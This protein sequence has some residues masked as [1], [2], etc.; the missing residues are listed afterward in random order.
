VAT[1][2]A[3]QLSAHLRISVLAMAVV[4]IGEVKVG[5]M[6]EIDIQKAKDCLDIP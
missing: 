3:V 1:G 6:G 2:L 4:V 5:E